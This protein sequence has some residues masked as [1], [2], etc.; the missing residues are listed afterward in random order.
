MDAE[1]LEPLVCARRFAGR[2]FSESDDAADGS[3]PSQNCSRSKNNSANPVLLGRSDRHT[4]GLSR[5]HAAYARS[6]C[7]S[8][9]YGSLQLWL[10]LGLLLFLCSTLLSRRL[11]RGGSRGLR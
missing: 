3:A 2:R 10:L 1:N 7:G 6:R 4:C 9:T 8:R 5:R 11:S